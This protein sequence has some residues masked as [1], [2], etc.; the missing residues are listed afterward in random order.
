MSETIRRRSDAY[1][2]QEEIRARN[3]Q[4]ELGESGSEPIK[5]LNAMWMADN[6]HWHEMWLSVKDCHSRGD[7]EGI[8][9]IM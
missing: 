1:N 2:M 3:K 4:V 9:Q 7:Y 8:I 6:S 5:V